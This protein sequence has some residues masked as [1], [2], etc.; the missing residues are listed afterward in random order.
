MFF[1]T[2]ECP[3][4][5]QP[6]TVENVVCILKKNLNTR[7][8]DKQ[9][10]FFYFNSRMLVVLLSVY[11]SYLLFASVVELLPKKNIIEIIKVIGFILLSLIKHWYFNL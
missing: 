1:G 3:D 10:V 7:F 4:A 2:Q 8:K 9:Q 11:K 6:I 5:V